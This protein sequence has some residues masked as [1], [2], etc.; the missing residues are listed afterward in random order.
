MIES[1]LPDAN[2]Y[3]RQTFHHVIEIGDD[4]KELKNFVSEADR[5]K[6]VLSQRRADELKALESRKGCAERW[7]SKV[8]CVNLLIYCEN[9]SVNYLDILVIFLC[10]K[11][12]IL[13]H[14][15][16]LCHIL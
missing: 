14:S 8:A 2:A 9:F 11:L 5:G 4:L 13:S 7:V 3:V 10:L 1:S 15:L 6:A 12:F 16:V